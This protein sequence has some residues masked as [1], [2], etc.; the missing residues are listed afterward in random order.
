MLRA[1]TVQ[2]VPASQL[3]RGFLLLICAGGSCFS[4]VQ[5]VPA[6]TVQGVPAVTVQ[7]VPA[8]LLWDW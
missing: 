2:G 3:C 4:S 5:G 1:V 8:S 7:G 6:A